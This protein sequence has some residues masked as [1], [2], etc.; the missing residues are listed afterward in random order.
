MNKCMNKQAKRYTKLRFFVYPFY[1]KDTEPLN[2]AFMY[3]PVILLLLTTY[4]CGSYF[5][6]WK[7]HNQQIGL[8]LEIDLKKWN[9]KRQD[10]NYG[11]MS[12]E[13]AALPSEPLHL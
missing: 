3:S 9:Q 6:Y 13:A 7:R 4:L 10:S 11:P 5:I 1:H 8:C 2:H 12:Y